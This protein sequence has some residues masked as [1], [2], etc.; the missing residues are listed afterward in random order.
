MELT[1]ENYLKLKESGKYTRPQM[2]GVF[3]IPDWKLKKWISSNNLGAKRPTIRN[4]RAFSKHSNSS[5]YWAGFLAADGCVDTKGR[6][7]L[8]LQLSDADHLEKFADFVGSNHVINRNKERNRC[9]LE[10]TCR[11]NG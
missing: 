10:F 11:G 8:Y 6:V 7:R 2:A 9:S 4:K 1:K 5:D 3:G